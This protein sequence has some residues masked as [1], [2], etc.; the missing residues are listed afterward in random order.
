MIDEIAAFNFQ[1]DNINDLYVQAVRNGSISQIKWTIEN[2][3]DIHYQKDMAL[4]TASTFKHLEVLKF[5][6]ND[7]GLKVINQE[8][9]LFDAC[10]HN[11]IGMI[12]FIVEEC[13]MEVTTSENRPIQNAVMADALEAFLY[14]KEKG[15]PI[16]GVDEKRFRTKGEPEFKV[17]TLANDSWR[18]NSTDCMREILPKNKR[19]FF[20]NS[21]II[22]EI[23]A[24][25]VMS[26]IENN[27]SIV[28]YVVGELLKFSPQKFDLFLSTKEKLNKDK[29]QEFS[30]W[31]QWFKLDQNLGEKKVKSKILKI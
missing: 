22:Y 5:L 23:N 16:N 17:S 9:C 10:R 4:D 24:T 13:G 26:K 21:N 8:R 18:F 20:S 29:Q 14:L 27:S 6:N 30:T 11:D 28:N 2:G 19:L 25:S 1:K 15:A 31:L 3:A 7:V 12:Q